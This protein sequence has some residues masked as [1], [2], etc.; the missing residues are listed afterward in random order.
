M[1]KI[2]AITV[3]LT[4]DDKRITLQGPEAFV[5]A[6][7]QRLT[8]SIT[9]ARPAERGSGE[10]RQDQEREAGHLTESKLMEVK[11]PSNH[12]ETVAVL[13]YCLKQQGTVEF[14]ED[15]IRR[16]YLRARV[17][18]PR[19]VGQAIRDAKNVFDYIEAGS[20]RGV[21]RLSH[22]GETTV[23]FDLPREQ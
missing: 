15:D 10:P 5:R 14:N 4:V 18:P 13:A 17:R 19:V 6:E 2:E 3:T 9:S 16:G 12:P 23:L 7:V 11:R 21:F 1:A 22:H 8:D 20:G